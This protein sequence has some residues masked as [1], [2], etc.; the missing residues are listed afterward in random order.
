MLTEVAL[1][2]ALMSGPPPGDDLVISE[3]PLSRITNGMVADV[4]PIG[5]P[6]GN[7]DVL[8]F[9]DGGGTLL[10]DSAV[11]RVE[12][13]AF[14]IVQPATADANPTVF[15]TSWLDFQNNQHTV[16]TDCSKYPSLT[17]CL[18]AHKRA[19]E[20]MAQAFPKSG[21]DI[22]NAIIKKE[23]ENVVRVPYEDH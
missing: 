7:L 11:W 23:E 14:L 6:D 18:E 2:V 1:L 12:D 17:K 13:D 5:A 10:A 8:L 22:I 20:I 4:L 9:M 15:Q 16:I 3:I 19:V 21:I